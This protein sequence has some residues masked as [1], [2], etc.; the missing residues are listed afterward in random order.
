MH[1][2]QKRF[3]LLCECGKNLGDVANKLCND[4][5]IDVGLIEWAMRQTDNHIQQWAKESDYNTASSKQLVAILRADNWQMTPRV[6]GHVQKRSSR[7]MGSQLLED[8]FNDQ[9]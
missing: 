4:V 1:G 3:A 7:L 9:K 8:G 6:A 5:Q 2:I